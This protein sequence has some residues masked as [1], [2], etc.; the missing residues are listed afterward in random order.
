[1]KLIPNW[2]SAS[3][4]ILS[5]ILI[6]TKPLSLAFFIIYSICGLSDAL[7]GFIARRTR[8]TSRFGAKLDSIADMI[9][10]GA[11][12]FLLYPVVN[13]SKEIIIWI[14]IIG[15]IRL[16]AMIVAIIKYKTFA[17]IH[18]YGNK[19]TGILLFIFPIFIIFIR[20]NILMQIVCIV[21]T[22]SAI[23]EFIIQVTSKQLNLNRQ[24]I[25]IK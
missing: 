20:I 8:T 4:I 2:I 24:S 7:D 6:Y 15:S 5:L 16:A 17:S 23:E 13:I 21:A 25:F 9:M 19:I 11:L 14:I 10:T 22:I 1:M 18:T 3:R 12:L